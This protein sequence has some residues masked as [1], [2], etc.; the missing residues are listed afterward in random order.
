[1]HNK[2]CVWRLAD[3]RPYVRASFFIDAG[4][5]HTGAILF[6]TFEPWSE[7]PIRVWLEHGAESCEVTGTDIAKALLSNWWPK[8]VRS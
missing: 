7:I 3:A 1:M 5:R 6:I 2:H 4:N 8:V